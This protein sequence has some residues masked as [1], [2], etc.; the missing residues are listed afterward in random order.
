M[1]CHR[2]FLCHIYIDLDTHPVLSRIYIR[3]VYRDQCKYDTKRN[4][5]KP[6][7]PEKSQQKRQTDKDTKKACM[8]RFSKTVKRPEPLPQQ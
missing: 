2:S 7:H 4:G 5:D 6:P 8:F 1:V 3:H